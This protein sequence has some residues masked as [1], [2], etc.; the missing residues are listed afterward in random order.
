VRRLGLIL[1]SALILLTS[2]VVLLGVASNRR[3]EPEARLVLTERELRLGYQEKENTG[4]WLRLEAADREPLSTRGPAWF[5]KTKLEEVGFD[6]SVPPTDS[7]AELFYEKALPRRVYALLELEGEAWKSYIAGREQELLNPP[8]GSRETRPLEERRKQLEAERAGHSRL[9]VVD[10]GRDAG[11]LRRRHPDRSRFIVTQAVVRLEL[12]RSW[13]DQTK[14]W[15]D[16]HLE[17]FVSEILPSEINVP[18]DRR[19]VLDDLRARSKPRDAAGEIAYSAYAY[20]LQGPP[21]YE[22]TLSYGRR[23]EP[24]IEEV[25][26]LGTPAD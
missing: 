24:W 8:P 5:D 14:T 1:A 10:V 25:R 3:G 19:R 21:R 12:D 13:D 22:V 9:F 6:C 26:T 7:S 16:G 23:L 17:G 11:D 4:L 18:L 2:A 20:Y 15:K